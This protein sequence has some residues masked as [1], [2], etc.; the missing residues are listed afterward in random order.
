MILK[1]FH[2]SLRMLNI[3]FSADKAVGGLLRFLFEWVDLHVNNNCKF[4]L[5]SYLPPECP[6][7]CSKC[8]LARRCLECDDGFAKITLP[9]K[10]SKAVC[11]PCSQQLS[12]KRK[13]LERDTSKC[14]FGKWGQHAFVISSMPDSWWSLKLWISLRLSIYFLF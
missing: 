13:G 11:V 14:P 3:F 12:K 4:C 10:R 9:K 1:V 8:G 5:S 6:I 7:N 2:I